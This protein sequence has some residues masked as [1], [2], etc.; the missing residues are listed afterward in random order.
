MPP[1]VPAQTP[2]VAPPAAEVSGNEIDA[3]VVAYGRVIEI[4][5]QFAPQIAQ[6]S[7]PREQD[8]LRQEALMAQSDPIDETPGIDVDRYVEIITLAQA[9]PDLNARLREKINQ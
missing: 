7:D 2:P 9:D 1:A 6:A 4:E 5:R 8:E 3:F